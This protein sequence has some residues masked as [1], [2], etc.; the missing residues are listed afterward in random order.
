ML[1]EFSIIALVHHLVFDHFVS[2][3]LNACSGCVALQPVQFAWR[4]DTVFA[5]S[6]P[7]KQEI[8]G[9]G[10]VIGAVREIAGGRTE[11]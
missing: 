10:D 4:R 9:T 6:E 8:H 2:W 3:V 1:W 5:S 7:L 11:D